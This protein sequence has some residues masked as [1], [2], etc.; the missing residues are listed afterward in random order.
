MRNPFE[1][2]PTDK[3]RTIFLPL[4]VATILIFIV[5]VLMVIPMSNEKAPLSVSSFGMAGNLSDAREMVASWDETARLSGT[6]GIGFDF[7]QLVVYPLTFAM[8]CVWLARMFKERGFSGLST[9]GLLIAWGQ[10]LAAVF[11]TVQNYVMMS[12]LL[13]GD[14]EFGMKVSFWATLFKLIFLFLGPAYAALGY[15]FWIAKGVHQAR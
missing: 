14:S 6:L 7:L 1:Q 9:L 13:G 4:L 15:L 2:I 10:L 3:R 12:V 8:A 11:G 5:W